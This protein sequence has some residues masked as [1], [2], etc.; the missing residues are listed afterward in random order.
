MPG[1]GARAGVV[2]QPERRAQT[3]FP[4]WGWAPFVDA[5]AGAL[6]HLA[7]ERG[8][9]R[10]CMVR[11]PHAAQAAGDVDTEPVRDRAPFALEFL[12]REVDAEAGAAGAAM[13]AGVVGAHA[14]QCRGWTRTGRPPLAPQAGASAEV[15]EVGAGAAGAGAAGAEATSPTT[16]AGLAP[17]TSRTTV[18]LQSDS[19]TTWAET[20]PR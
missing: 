15:E 14:A 9:A 4:A 11:T 1:A 6:A 19:A 18:T 12:P 8:T 20:L 7:D 10:L 16:G 2:T 3:E 13:Q 5:A 17:A